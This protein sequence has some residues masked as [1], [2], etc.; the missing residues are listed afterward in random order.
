MDGIDAG[1]DAGPD[2][3]PLYGQRRK[4]FIRGVVYIAVGAMMLPILAGL[5]SVNAA[6]AARA[7]VIATINAAPDATGTAVPFEIFG[8]GIIG[9][10]CYATGTFGGDRHIISLGLLPGFVSLPTG[11]VRT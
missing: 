2:D 11:G 1:P 8:P 10:E 5:Y 6:A 3:R 9:W 7:C 4:R